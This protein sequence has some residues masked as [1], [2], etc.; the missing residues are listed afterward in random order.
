[1]ATNFFDGAG[2]LLLDGNTA[3]CRAKALK[4]KRSEFSIDDAVAGVGNPQPNRG[5][6]LLGEEFRENL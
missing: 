3:I 5:C 1:M 2:K 6:G 4:T